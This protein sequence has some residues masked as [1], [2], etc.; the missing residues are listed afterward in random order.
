[1][2]PPKHPATKVAKSYHEPPPCFLRGGR[3]PGE[4][5]VIL[6]FWD[7]SLYSYQLVTAAAWQ[8][9]LTEAACL[10]CWFN[11]RWRQR[12]PGQYTRLTHVATELVETFFWDPGAKRYVIVGH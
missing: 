10:G 2:A 5:V 1:M 6:Q 4:D 9:F 7:N 12:P 8:E 3:I 11:P